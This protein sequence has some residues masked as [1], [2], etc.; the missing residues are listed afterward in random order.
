MKKARALISFITAGFFGT[1]LAT[2]T[3]AEEFDLSNASTAER[4]TYRRAVDAAVWAMSLLNFK[5]YRDALA[6]AGV[7]R[8]DVGCYSRVRDWRFQTATPNN[9]PNSSY[10][11]RHI[12]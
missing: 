1:V 2:T 10:F 4:M 12:A 9:T 8:I 6:G 11:E 3:N 7:G 5:I